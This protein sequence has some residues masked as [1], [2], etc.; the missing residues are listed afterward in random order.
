MDIV[1]DQKQIS[2]EEKNQIRKQ[3]KADLIDHLYQGCL[4]GTISG[5]IA[6]IAIFLDYYHYTSTPLLIGW[7]VLFNVMMVSLS[8]LYFAYTKYR[9]KLDLTS[10]E[11]AYALTM[12]GCA[13][14]WMPIIYLFPTDIT[15]Q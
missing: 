14:S 15:R 8:L 11:R 9:S 7:L 1:A 12:T 5:I 2:L 3:V 13:L 10:W 4:P 6:S